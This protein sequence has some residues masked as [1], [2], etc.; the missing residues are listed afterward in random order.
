L[1]GDVGKGYA[2]FFLEL[3]LFLLDLWAKPDRIGVKLD[4]GKFLKGSKNEKNN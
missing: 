2:G 4:L 1:S 3:E